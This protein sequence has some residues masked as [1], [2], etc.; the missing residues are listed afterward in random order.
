MIPFILSILSSTIIFILFKLFKRFEINT[1]QAIVFNYFTAAGIGFALY[2]DTWNSLA[3]EQNNWMAYSIM[4]SLLFISLFFLMG[5][6]SQEN[7]VAST[8]VAV[9][10][11]MAISIILLIIYH[12]EAPSLTKAMGIIFA[13]ISV[14]LVSLPNEKSEPVSNRRWTLIVLFFGGGALDFL[15][16]FVQETQLTVLDPSLFSAISL[17]L[18]GCIGVILLS[19]RLLKRKTTLALKNVVAGV[20]LGIPNFFS[21]YFLL[22]AYRTSGWTDTTVL[23]LTN[24]SVVLGTVIIGFVLF[25]EA[26]TSKKMRGLVVALLAIITLYLAER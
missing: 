22:L 23:A 2:G 4:T 13:F 14:I 25:K 6:S 8:S 9:K 19:F 11:S 7:G 10:M 21:I 26:R 3:W 1:F 12:S 5:L 20:V 17:G 16:N 24:V 18:A 15:L